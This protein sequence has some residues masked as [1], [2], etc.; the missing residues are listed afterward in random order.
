MG[1]QSIVEYG[2]AD[3]PIDRS[4]GGT[5]SSPWQWEAARGPSRCRAWSCRLAGYSNLQG[6]GAVIVD[7][8]QVVD[9]DPRLVHAK[10]VFGPGASP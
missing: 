8:A 4:L 5:P 1:I 2:E 6:D 9:V 7:D 10:D 3:M